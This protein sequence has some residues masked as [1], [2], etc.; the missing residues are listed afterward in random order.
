[1]M[2]LVEL[3]IMILAFGGGVLIGVLIWD[4]LGLP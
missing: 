3:A 1:M 4:W 2:E